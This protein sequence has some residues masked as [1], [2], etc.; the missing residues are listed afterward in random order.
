MQREKVFSVIT[1]ICFA[2]VVFIPIG[3][4]LMFYFTD[5]KR[6]TKIIT[7]SILTVLYLGIALLLF[8]LQSATNSE[9][10]TVPVEYEKGSTEFENNGKKKINPDDDFEVVEGKGK[11]EIENP[12]DL[13]NMELPSTIK[14]ENR[15]KNNRWFFPLMFFLFMLFLIIVQNIKSSKKNKGYDNPYVDMS[16]YKIPIP[17]D[18]KFPIVHFLKLNLHPGENYLYAT[19]TTQKDNEGNFVITNE[20]VVIYNKESE[21]TYKLGELTQAAS[22]SNNVMVLTAGEEKNYIFLPDD[23]MKYALAI[24]RYAFDKFGGNI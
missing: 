5:W 7:G 8:K 14:K 22:V 10:V 11:T 9:G 21:K 23:Q 19:E 3:L 24:V 18:F 20:R 15:N 16:K 6:K 1:I 12:E 17:D 13:D 2:T 4:V